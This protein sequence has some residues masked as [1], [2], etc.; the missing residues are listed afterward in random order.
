MAKE[1]SIFAKLKDEVSPGLKTMRSEVGALQKGMGDFGGILSPISGNLGMVAG[2]LGTAAG[3]AG[4]L[5]GA[6]A[7]A[8]AGS[9]A[10]NNQMAEQ[11]HELEIVS[12]RTGVSVKTLQD[13]SLVTKEAGV[14][15]ESF[16]RGFKT[17]NAQIALASQGNKKAVKEFTDLGVSIQDSSGKI[18]PTEAIFKDVMESLRGVG[19]EAVQSKDMTD[20]FGRSG[21]ALLPIVRMDKEELN[22]LIAAYQEYGGYFSDEQLK[23]YDNYRLQ[24]M[25]IAAA[26]NKAKMELSGELLPATT[27]LLILTK[28]S[29]V[30]VGKN[31]DA[32]I[33]LLENAFMPLTGG[34]R[35]VALG[36]REVAEAYHIWMGDT[37]EW[38]AMQA[39]MDEA[40]KKLIQDNLDLLKTG[41][42]LSSGGFEMGPKQDQL[43]KW[44]D[45]RRKKQAAKVLKDQQDEVKRLKESREYAMDEEYKA[46]ELHDKYIMGE[47]I[48]VNEAR[49]AMEEA[50]Y[51]KRLEMKKNFEDAL[52]ALAGKAIEVEIDAL[53]SGHGDVMKA[54]GKMV[55]DEAKMEGDKYILK[56]AAKIAESI[57]PPNPAGL[58]SGTEEVAG[59]AALYAFG[60]AL[61]GGGAGAGAKAA[62][63][64]AGVG[65]VA[66]A[67]AAAVQ[68][69]QKITIDLIGDVNPDTLFSAKRVKQILTSAGLQVKEGSALDIGSWASSH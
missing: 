50:D 16:G 68:P 3:A 30:W 34:L 14:D 29:V 52:G 61:A 65:K 4:L 2:S 8:V 39:K 38:L 66:G 18:R 6:S 10:L 25:E 36:Y 64:A 35:L 47:T 57:W 55:G 51:Q 69:Q 22:N 56:G 58:L 54:M 7:A 53:I 45:D 23:Q 12:Q 24:Q 44:A 31:K 60:S 11:A 28:D 21:Q 19:D 5:I 15:N 59:G 20:L 43:D 41:D 62:K 42:E 32:I 63:G 46:N 17:L 67:G 40:E 33:D 48:K 13:W 9:I 37:P 1:I 27:E 26:Y 49:F